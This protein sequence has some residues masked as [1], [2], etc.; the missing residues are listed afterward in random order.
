MIHLSPYVFRLVCIST[1]VGFLIG[2]GSSL[3]QTVPK[4][5]LQRLP[6]NSRRSVFQAETVVTIAID[7]KGKIK[8]RKEGYLR[9]IARTKEKIKEVD[10]RL[11]KASGDKVR[12]IE[13]EID[14]LESK[15]EY[16]DF[17]ADHQDIRMELAE[18]ELMLARAQFELSKARLVKK[19]SIAFSED[20]EDFEEQVA[21]EREK[22]KDIRREVKQETEELKREEER[23]LAAKKHY[24]SAIGESSKGWW[25]EQ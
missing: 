18:Q 8:R 7:N 25:T 12:Q 15:I 20:V 4:E 14:M 24:Y 1:L 2:C 3:S 9:E 22:V 13:M 17:A 23:W 5:L 19:H 11:D 16:L 21:A 6:K 10:E